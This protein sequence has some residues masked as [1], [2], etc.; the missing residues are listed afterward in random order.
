MVANRSEWSAKGGAGRSNAAR[1]RK[2]VGSFQDLKVARGTMVRVLT[3]LEAGEIEP[4]IATA[5]ATVVRA[6]D[7]VTKTTVLAELD[8]RMAE[9]S[10]QIATLNE[11]QAG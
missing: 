1:A 7:A 5:M 11:R 3:K 9:M 4:A 2:A 8:E 10:Q 6:L